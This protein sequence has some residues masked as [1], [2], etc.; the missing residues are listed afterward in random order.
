[1]FTLCCSISFELWSTDTWHYA[2]LIYEVYN[3]TFTSSEQLASPGKIPAEMVPFYKNLLRPDP[4]SRPSVG[5][6]LDK[7]MQAKGFF[8]NDLIQIVNFLENFSVKEPLQR[9]TFLRKLDMQIDRLPQE[10]CKYKVL[11]ELVQA[12]EYGSG[13]AKVLAPIVKIGANL[14]EQEYE[15]LISNVL[16]KMFSSTDRSIRL[17]LLENLSGFIERIN[18]KIVNDKIFPSMVR[19]YSNRSFILAFLCDL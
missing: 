19:F 13:G 4:K 7:G 16:V 10:F 6:F 17:S 15:A 8:Q 1:M 5:D 12:L 14:E 18:K 2:C 3:G 11:P 9:D